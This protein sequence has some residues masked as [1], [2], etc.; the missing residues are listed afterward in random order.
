MLHTLKLMSHCVN[1]TSI[2]KE[3]IVNINKDSAVWVR[4]QRRTELP[5]KSTRTPH[6]LP[7]T[8][9]HCPQRITSS[10]LRQTPP[11]DVPACVKGG[12]RGSVG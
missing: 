10:H 8:E 1:A 3:N 11:H 6:H 2:Q 4:V 5:S 9:L 7:V 12:H